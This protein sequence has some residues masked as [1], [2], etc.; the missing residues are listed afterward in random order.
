MG[1]KRKE[2]EKKIRERVIGLPW[3]NFLVLNEHNPLGFSVG[4]GRGGFGGE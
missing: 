2:E 3:I 1:Q 4:R